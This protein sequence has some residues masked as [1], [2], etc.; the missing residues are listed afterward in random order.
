MFTRFKGAV[1]DGLG[2]DAADRVATDKATK[3]AFLVGII[4]LEWWSRTTNRQAG[5]CQQLS[6]ASLKFVCI[7]LFLVFGA[8][9]TNIHKFA[10]RYVFL[11]SSFL[12]RTRKSDDKVHKSAVRL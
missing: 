9:M 10:P 7:L 8:H 5:F 11:H 12:P 1:V 4:R 2:I 6:T 3:A